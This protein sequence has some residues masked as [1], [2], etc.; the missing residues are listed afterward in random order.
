MTAALALGCQVPRIR[1]VPPYTHTSG[2]EVAELAAD[3]GLVLDPWQQL[4]LNDAQAE[5]ER[6]MWV[7]FECGI[8]VSRQNGKGGIFEAR[9]LAGLFLFDE[10]LIL[11]SAH[12]FKTASEMF[13]RIKDLIDGKDAYRR[14]VRRVITSHGEEGIELLSG[15]RLRIIARSRSSG[16][17]F[18]GDCNIMD[19][20]FRL[21]PA[22]MAALLP[23][24]S[25]RRNP[26]L[27]YGSSAGFEDSYQLGAV[28][29]RGLAGDD[30]SLCFHEYSAPDDTL[31]RLQGRPLADVKT[32]L[33]DRGLWAMAN[34]ALGIRI[35]EDYIA[36]ELRAMDPESFARERLG[37]GTYPM[38][39]GGWQVIGE[40]LW[41]SCIDPG[42]RRSGAI[43][44]CLD[45]PPDRS[46]G[47][48]A[49]AGRRA[50]GRVHGELIAYERGTG[51]MVERA[52]QLAADHRPL[53]IVVDGAGPAG[54]LIAP[55]Q[56][57]GLEVTVM[58]A[59]DMAQ[60]CG[61][62]YDLIEQGQFRT[63]GQAP[64][65][66]AVA[67]AVKRVIGD[68]GWGWARRHA[69]VDISPIVAVTGAAWGLATA[70]AEVDPLNN[71]W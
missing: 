34:P 9:V 66:T 65:T 70:P 8:I 41:T 64:L 7:C 61:G 24:M 40:E 27:F 52:A 56:Q 6:G 28:R 33:A 42:S 63:I 21:G 14:R 15:Q 22:E 31:S 55:L 67:G 19:E 35:S 58:G 54:S 43:A 30:P 44:L 29:Q 1:S 10:R 62:L 57:A 23:T 4:F 50:D 45:V 53:A 3:V 39:E 16:R 68:G 36:K 69:S 48:I 37:I 17:G 46:M 12:E 47:V 26:Q 49:V 25:A 18:S 60:A 20:A 38:E 59:R 11:Y 32:A 2:P 13:L 51:W 71:I 5:D